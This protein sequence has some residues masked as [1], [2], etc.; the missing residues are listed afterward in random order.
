MTFPEGMRPLH[1]LR[2]TSITNDAIAGADP[3]AP[4]TMAGHANMAKRKR[5]LRLGGAVFPD[6]A[7]ALERRMLGAP[8][9]NSGTETAQAVQVSQTA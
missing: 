7:E 3:T 6:E 9:P 5:Y 2:V 8:V 1:D 4:M